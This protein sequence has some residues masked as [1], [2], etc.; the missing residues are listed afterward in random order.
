[1]AEGTLDGYVDCMPSPHGPWDYLGGALVCAE[2]GA[3]VADAAG[4]EL[5]V[6]DPLARRTPVAGATPALFEALLAARRR[7]PDPAA[8]GPSVTGG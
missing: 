6:L 2:A 8:A 1:M 7:L 3:L 5:T 4:R